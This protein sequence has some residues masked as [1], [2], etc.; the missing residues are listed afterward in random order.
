MIDEM[1]QQAS[2]AADNTVDA[3]TD[4]VRDGSRQAMFGVL[5]GTALLGWIL[6]RQGAPALENVAAS[7]DKGV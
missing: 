1:M 4:I 6:A 2:Q 7:K 3:A 5:A